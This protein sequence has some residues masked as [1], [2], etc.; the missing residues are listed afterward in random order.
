MSTRTV[1]L[2]SKELDSAIEVL[3]SAKT[4]QLT[5]FEKI[6][7]RALIFS[8]DVAAACYIA[9]N[10]WNSYFEIHQFDEWSFSLVVGLLF[11]LALLVGL[12]ALALNTPLFLR[13]FRERRTRRTRS[14]FSHQ[15]PLEGE[16]T[17]S[18]DKQDSWDLVD[19][20]RH[21]FRF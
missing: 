21:H 13:A 11:L 4:L 2:S 15:I 17:E 3:S 6:S 14:Q 7:Y 19:G 16:S 5:R 1:A 9:D 10:A 8:V 18:M 20:N 12:V